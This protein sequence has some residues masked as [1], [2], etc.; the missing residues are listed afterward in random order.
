MTPV[1]F[2][3]GVQLVASLLINFFMAHQIILF[4][5]IYVFYRDDS[6]Y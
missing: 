4:I 2:Y 6:Y 5:Q 3:P 1:H